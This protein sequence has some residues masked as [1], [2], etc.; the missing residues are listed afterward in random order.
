MNQTIAT[1][2]KSP[3]PSLLT[4]TRFHRELGGTVGIN[5]LRTAVRVGRIRSLRVG[6]RKRLIPAS[7][8][9]DWPNRETGDP[10]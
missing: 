6:E 5:A 10:S 3:R 7:E 8:L 4:I 9:T 2:Q 1:H